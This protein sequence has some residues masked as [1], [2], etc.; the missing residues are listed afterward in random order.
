MKIP[1]DIERILDK[2]VKCLPNTYY[3]KDMKFSKD[4][5]ARRTCKEVRC[6]AV[7]L[8]PTYNTYTRGKPGYWHDNVGNVLEDLLSIKEHFL[9]DSLKKIIVVNDG[10][11][12]KTNEVLEE[13][14]RRESKTIDVINIPE[15]LGFNYAVLAG[16]EK[17]LKNNP[18]II[19]KMDS[20]GETP[21]IFI[22]ELLDKMVKLDADHIHYGTPFSSEM[23]TGF[24][25]FRA[26]RSNIIKDLLPFFKSLF[27]YPGSEVA[28]RSIDEVLTS[29]LTNPFSPYRIVN[30]EIKVYRIFEEDGETI[31]LA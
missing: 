8:M 28:G 7:A 23:S 15:N 30:K 11:T 20:D 24:F 2:T 3:C 10:S 26:T 9:K 17:A 25:G 22:T 6:D 16:Y 1:A 19:V 21:P 12:D 13:L 29:V 14:V 5:L 4:D 18:K 31:R 27:I